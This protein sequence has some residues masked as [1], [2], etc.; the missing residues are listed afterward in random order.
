LFYTEL[1]GVT[2]QSIGVT[3][4]TDYNLF[5]NI[6][7]SDWNKPYWTSTTYS[8]GSSPNDAFF[9]AMVN[10]WQDH[11]NKNS[12]GFAWAVRN[13]DVASTNAVPEPTSIT[14]LGLGALGFAASRRKKSV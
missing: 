7:S 12:L 4:D 11:F 6:D 13:G 5:Q 1:G 14:L 9:F 10:G 2:G 3:H 8:S